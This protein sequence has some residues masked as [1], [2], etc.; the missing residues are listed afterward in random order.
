MR[1]PPTKTVPHLY[2]EAPQL[3]FSY[4]VMIAL[5]TNPPLWF[6]IMNPRVDCWRQIFY[7]D[8]VEWGAYENGSIGRA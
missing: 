1:V 7:P 3:P 4:P 5:A 6:R 2:D 8:V